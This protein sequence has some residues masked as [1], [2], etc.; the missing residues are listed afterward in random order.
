MDQSS[1]QIS[2]SR[3]EPERIESVLATIQQ[4]LSMSKRDR[5]SDFLSLLLLLIPVFSG[6]LIGFWGARR[7]R[8]LV[9]RELEFGI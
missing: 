9:H 2:G 3:D 6:L 1:G 4:D 5:T 7:W 8:V